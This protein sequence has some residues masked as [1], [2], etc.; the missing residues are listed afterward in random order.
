[1]TSVE[2]IRRTLKE[3]QLIERVDYTIQPHYVAGRIRHLY[4]I[5]HTPRARHVVHRRAGTIE[6]R[7]GQYGHQWYVRIRRAGDL[8]YLAVDDRQRNVGPAAA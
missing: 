8:R 3:L 5:L 1:M 4:L 2:A 7:T 6:N